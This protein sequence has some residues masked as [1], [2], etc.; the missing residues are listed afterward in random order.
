VLRG[1]DGVDVAQ[2]Q[3][4]RATQNLQIVRSRVSSGASAGTEGKQAEVDRGRAEVGLIQAQRQFREARAL[5]AE[6][7]GVNVDGGTQLSSEF[8]VFE[9]EWELEALM[10]V[11]QGTPV[12]PIL[13]GSGTC[14]H[15][16]GQTGSQSVLPQR[17]HQYRPQR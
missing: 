17:L 7:I 1:Q 16:F 14:G 6:Q 8:T 3:L 5:L 13:R 2:R 12:A 15:C 9:P 11:A 10:D 4:D